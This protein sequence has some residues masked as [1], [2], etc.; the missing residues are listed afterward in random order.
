MTPEET[1]KAARKKGMEER[2]ALVAK[3]LRKFAPLKHKY[4]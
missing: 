4:K 1:K 3:L 2:K